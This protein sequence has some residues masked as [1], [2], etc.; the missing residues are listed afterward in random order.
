MLHQLGYRIAADQQSLTP[1]QRKVL[2]YGYISFVKTLREAASRSIEPQRKVRDL[3]E[4]VG[5][6]P[7]KEEKNGD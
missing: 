5:L 6:L 3:R 1:L 4:L 2:V 7:K